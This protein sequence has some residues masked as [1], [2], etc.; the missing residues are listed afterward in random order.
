MNKQLK[1]ISLV[2]SGVVLGVAISFSGEIS[3]ATSKLLGGKVGKV[4]TVTLDDKSIGEAPVIGGT[5]YVPVRAAANELGLEVAVEGNE[6]KLTTPEDQ[7]EPDVALPGV[8]EDNSQSDEKKIEL[9]KKIEGIKYSI[10]SKEKT[11]ELKQKQLHDFT[12]AAEAD[13][14]GKTPLWTMVTEMQKDVDAGQK[15]VDE[16]KAELAELEAQL[17]AL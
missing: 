11:L 8:D 3:A 13:P 16:L 17:A 1:N 4:M 10:N 5:S 15:T 2:L 7:T 12:T 14:S 9:T 6:V